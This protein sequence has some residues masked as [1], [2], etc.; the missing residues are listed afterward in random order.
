MS[1]HSAPHKSGW[2]PEARQHAAMAAGCAL[3][4]KSA[5]PPAAPP[6]HAAH[7][8]S[9]NCRSAR[10]ASA[11]RASRMPPPA[12]ATD[13]C[14]RTRS[15]DGVVQVLLA[16]RAGHR[17]GGLDLHLQRQG[18]E[19]L[20]QLLHLLGVVGPR[21]DD[22]DLCEAGGG[23]AATCRRGR[24]VGSGEDQWQRTASAAA[25]RS[26]WAAPTPGFARCMGGTGTRL[27]ARCAESAHAH[28][29]TVGH[30][31]LHFCIGLAIS[32]ADLRHL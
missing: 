32:N 21:D 22:A 12:L 6:S 19:L 23:V 9:C 31:V 29:H 20:E 28:V 15:L 1:R 16:Q 13:V 27:H 30:E 7:L 10:H 4:T 25:M 8:Q 18:I 3:C 17:D 11:V 2:Q 24:G 14:A 5:A 26:R